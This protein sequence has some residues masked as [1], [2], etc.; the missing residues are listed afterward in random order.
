MS[1]DARDGPNAGRAGVDA[2]GMVAAMAAAV[3]GVCG[4]CATLTSDV[5]AAVL[6]P[7]LMPRGGETGS[8]ADAG[9]N[10][11]AALAGVGGTAG[12]LLL[13]LL[14][15]SPPRLGTFCGRALIL[16]LPT[17][18]PDDEE[19][20]ASKGTKD[21]SAASTAGGWGE[22]AGGSWL[23]GRMEALRTMGPLTAGGDDT[24]PATDRGDGAANEIVG[25]T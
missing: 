9:S 25:S 19:E 7:T 17:P 24:A 3:R 2:L 23:W 12:R 11:A 10:D 14:L 5:R 8:T 21:E 1:R 13:W 16:C 4:T 22:G 15:S 20:R 6:V 18:P